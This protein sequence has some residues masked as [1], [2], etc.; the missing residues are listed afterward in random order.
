MKAEFDQYA[1]DYC[2]LLEEALP[3]TERAEY[4]STY[5]VDLLA[6]R[7]QHQSVAAVLDFGC[8]TGRSIPY[9]AKAFPE[10]TIYGFDP[11]EECLKLAE[12]RSNALFESEIERLPKGHFDIILAANVF[13]HVS[14]D[15]R[16]AVLKTCASLLADEGRIALFEHNP[17]NPL[18]RW[19]FERC[20][21]DRDAQML[22]MS[23]A[24]NLAKNAGLTVS[25]NAY[26]LFVPP[27]LRRLRFI[28]RALGR[29]PLGAQYYV[30]ISK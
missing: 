29:L 25:F 20:V 27:S 21:F 13:H 15:E 22:P 19:V 12:S 28:E 1:G 5:K 6:Q 14:V 8:G 16:P 24:K 26:T 30:E 9:L 3:S 18:T 23:E 4:F 11:S 17:F 7:V 2:R 10:A